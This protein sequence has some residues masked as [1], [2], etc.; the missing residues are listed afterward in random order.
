MV[1]HLSTYCKTHLIVQDRLSSWKATVTARHQG[2]LQKGIQW[3]LV[4]ANTVKMLV[5]KS[6]LRP[7]RKPH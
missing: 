3:T 2:V 5:S 4:K 1:I 6:R 7:H